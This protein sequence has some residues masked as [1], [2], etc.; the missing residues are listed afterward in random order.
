MKLLFEFEDAVVGIICGLLLIGFTGRFFS[1]K[2]GNIVY[3]TPFVVFSIAIILDILFE[4]TNLKVH[5]GFTII[6]IIHSIIDFIISITFIT[7]FS[8]WNIPLITS[9]FVPYLQNEV[10]IFWIG[11]FLVVSNAIWLTIYPFF[12]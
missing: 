10:F 11:I 3:I 7:Y 12:K 4:F 6:S 8:G 9:T 1:L 5:F 2:F